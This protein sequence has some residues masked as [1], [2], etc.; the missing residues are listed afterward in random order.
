MRDMSV[1][2]S[3]DVLDAVRHLKD[4]VDA[5]GINS[6][7]WRSLSLVT[8]A[9]RTWALEKEKKELLSQP[10]HPS[11]KT[12]YSDSSVYDEVCVYCGAT[13]ASGS[14][15]LKKPCPEAPT[16]LVGDCPLCAVEKS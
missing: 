16:H 7:V 3:R 5:F 13:D 9:A 4:A 12:R 11:H 8:D 1:V 6:E 2:P 10:D 14:V 15:G